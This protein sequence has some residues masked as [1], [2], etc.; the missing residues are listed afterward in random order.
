MRRR[1]AESR[2]LD[3]GRQIRACAPHAYRRP[4]APAPPHFPANYVIMLVAVLVCYVAKHSR[5][6]LELDLD[7][8]P[9][10]ACLDHDMGA[11]NEA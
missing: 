9:T 6:S 5:A 4:A 8:N 3:L 10:D 1:A 7:F 11:G 2:G